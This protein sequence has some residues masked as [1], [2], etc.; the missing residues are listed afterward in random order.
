[1]SFLLYGVFTLIKTDRTMKHSKV[2]KGKIIEL[3]REPVART[4]GYFPVI[5]YFDELEQEL[6]TF[7]S[8]MGYDKNKFQIGET[9]E[10]R[11]YI[12]NNKKE[13]MINNWSSVWGKG[14]FATVFGFIFF[15]AGLSGP[16][17]LF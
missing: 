5:E 9:V 10:V 8:L 2:T 11:Y 17:I 1:M 3:S 14:V 13:L 16:I 7:K 6:K 4:I 15:L 12:K